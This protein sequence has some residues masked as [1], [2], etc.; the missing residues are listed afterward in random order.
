MQGIKTYGKRFIIGWIIS[1]VLMFVLSYI[2]HGV[3][4]YD[5][6]QIT[7]PLG[8]YLTASAIAYL[9][10]GFLVNRAFVIPFFDRISRHPLLRGPAIGFACGMLVYIVAT[11]VHV[12]FNKDMELKYFLLDV[13][14]QGIEQAFGGFV[15]GLVYMFVYEPHPFPVEKEN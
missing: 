4:L 13:T 11:V 7:Y 1:S 9:F 3:V 8:I 14:W 2:W 5:Y 10:I 12:T 6:A 15:V